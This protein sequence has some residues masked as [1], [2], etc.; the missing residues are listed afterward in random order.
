MNKIEI[1]ENLKKERKIRNLTQQQ[2]AELLNVSHDTISLW[3][4]GK[5]LPDLD[6]L[7]NLAKIFELSIDDLIG[8]NDFT[9]YAKKKISSED[10]TPEEIAMI[11]KIRLLGPYEQTYIK[12]QIDALSD[13]QKSK[14]KEKI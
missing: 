7:M 5:S 1:S 14:Q 10:F 11:Q 13:T 6:S 8:R 2:L 4:L 12:A 9:S 3:E